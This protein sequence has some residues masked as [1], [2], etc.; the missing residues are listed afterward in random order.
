MRADVGIIGGGASGIAAA[1]AAG[2]RGE[3]VTLLESMEQIGKKLLATG[4]GRCNLLN[5]VSP[6]YYG[7]PEFAARVMGKDPV[8]ELTAFWRSLGLYLRYDREGR[9]YPYTGMA[10]T[11]L[12]VLKAEIRRLPVHTRTGTRATAIRKSGDGFLIQSDAGENIPVRRVIIATGGAAQPRLGGNRSAWPWLQ[13]Y[14]H[15]MTPARPSL[16]SLKTDTRSISGLAGLRVRGRVRLEAGNRILHAE[17]G[18]VLFT[19]RGVSGICVMQCSRFYPDTGNSAT[20]R[21]N[22]TDGLFSDRNELKTELKK[23]RNQLPE[24]EPADLL[25]G[26]CAQKLGYAVCKQAGLALRGEKNSS[27]TDTQIDKLAECLTGY[28]LRITGTDGF[29]KAQVMAGGAAC[30]EFSPR[31]M[32]SQKCSGLHATGELLNV[33]GDCGGF[34]LMFAFL[35]GI[36]AGENRRQET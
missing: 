17:T 30:G 6:V 2:R 12:E 33:D 34:N 35:S 22:L 25:R 4:N 9:G 18:E 36:R 24:E 3:R 20:L 19:E 27:L 15:S 11:V 10:T 21:I 14:G 28:A 13:A 16:V 5:S 32:E 31:N 8:G 29:E 7:D 23:R 26:I 1:I